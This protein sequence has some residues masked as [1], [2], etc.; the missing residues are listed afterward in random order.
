MRDILIG[1]IIGAIITWPQS[2]G[3]VMQSESIHNDA[4]FYLEYLS[5]WLTPVLVGWA[6]YWMS[7]RGSFSKL[8]VVTMSLFTLLPVFFFD[9]PDAGFMLL[10]YS[11]VWQFIPCLVL[12]LIVRKMALQ[13]DKTKY[14]LTALTILISVCVA[15]GLLAW[16]VRELENIT[17]WVLIIGL[18]WI[19]IKTHRMP[20]QNS[21]AML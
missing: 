7:I 16:Y 11:F 3:Y 18:V 20:A 5:S 13:Q 4:M 10:V 14:M 9:S 12:G 8:G 2:L 15:L 21:S 6:V 17:M 19:G 1:A